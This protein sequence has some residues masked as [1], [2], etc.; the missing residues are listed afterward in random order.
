MVS[1]TPLARLERGFDGETSGRW[2]QEETIE[3]VGRS[4]RPVCGEFNEYRG[5]RLVLRQK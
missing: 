4:W 1:L 3:T 2:Q 5:N